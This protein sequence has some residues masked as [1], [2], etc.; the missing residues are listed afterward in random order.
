MTKKRGGFD[1]RAIRIVKNR[2]FAALKK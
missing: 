1:R 2:I